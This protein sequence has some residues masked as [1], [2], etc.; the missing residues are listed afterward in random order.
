[1]HVFPLSISLISLISESKWRSSLTYT[2][3]ALV[4]A[5][6]ILKQHSNNCSSSSP[7]SHKALS[8]SAIASA[9][10]AL[11]IAGIVAIGIRVSCSYQSALYIMSD[12]GNTHLLEYLT[13]A[14]TFSS[15]RLDCFPHCFE[16][17]LC[18][19]RIKTILINPYNPHQIGYRFSRDDSRYLVD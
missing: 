15:Y 5:S 4:M 19:R 7:P 18:Q 6:L 2:F 11:G 9:A 12:G 16:S 17:S 3:Y 10:Y 14:P 8:H 1:M 13:C